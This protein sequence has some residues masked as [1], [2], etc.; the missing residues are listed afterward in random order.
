MPG[1]VPL[2]APR[3]ASELTNYLPDSWRPIIDKDIDGEGATPVLIDA[4]RPAFGARSLTRR[5]ARTIFLE[6][7]A[8][9][10]TDHKGVER[11]RLWLG[12][13]IPGDT[14]GN[15]GASLEVL[16]QRATYLYTEDARYSFATTASVTRTAADIADRLREEPERVWNEI[17]RRLPE[18]VRERGL[19]AGVHVAPLDDADV[20]DVDTARL[21]VVHPKYR[22]ARGDEKSTA[23]QWANG[24]L[25][26]VGSAQR[27]F[28]NQV[29]FLA[30]DAARYD[31]LDAAVRDFLAWK[32]VDESA[33]TLNL[34]SQQAAQAASRRRQSDEDVKNRLLATYTTLLVPVQPQ[35]T[36]PPG[37][38]ADRLP[39]SGAGLAIR[40]SEKLRRG[41]ELTD[42]YG[43][44]GVR[45]ALNTDIASVWKTGNVRV[46][47]LWSLYAQ[48]RTCTGCGTAPCWSVRCSPRSRHGC[49]TPTGSPSPKGTTSGPVGIWGS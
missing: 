7:A 4:G 39:E 25:L 18:L 16:S 49:G 47:D 22:H 28:R 31:D 5:I 20:P 32:Q 6:S 27:R 13:A 23:W 9:L 46:G 12:V 24:A 8:T 41:D 11:P 19:F 15:F 3:V 21:V 40:A 36:E 29:V 42:S 44:L 14:V 26:R 48:S 1:S 38:R 34:T 33:T 30:A 2:H 43:A 17:K 35:P 37:L 10:G 45:I